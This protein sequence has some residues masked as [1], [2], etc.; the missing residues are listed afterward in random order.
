MNRL[1]FLI[2]YFLHFLF[3]KIID[4][5]VEE[6]AQKLR[7]LS[8]KYEHDKKLWVMAISGL[9]EKIKVIPICLFSKYKK[10]LGIFCYLNIIKYC[11]S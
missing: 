7:A 11:V 1:A 4:Q 8:E 6:Q 3:Q 5:T 2:F 9:E 10:Y